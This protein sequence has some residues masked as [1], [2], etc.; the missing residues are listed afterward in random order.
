MEDKGGL[1]T[2]TLSDVEL[3]SEFISSHGD[4]KPGPDIPIIP[5][6]GFSARMDE[7]KAM[8][9]GIRAFVSKPILKREIAE[10][11]RSVLDG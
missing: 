9:I 3:D 1:L 4:L 10:A 8:A 11:I 7:R 6:T 5:C 2:V